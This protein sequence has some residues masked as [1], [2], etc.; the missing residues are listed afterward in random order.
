MNS[1]VCLRYN[2]VLKYRTDFIN[3]DIFRKTSDPA[4]M[5]DFF[6]YI[7]SFLKIVFK[8]TSDVKLLQCCWLKYMV[9][10]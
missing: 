8:K 5:A 2:D 10:S 7:K 9:M 4:V 6:D 1:K 3:V